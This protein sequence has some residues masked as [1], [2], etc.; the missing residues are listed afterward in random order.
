MNA[1]PLKCVSVGNQGCSMVI[2]N[3]NSN[4]SLFCFCS[5][6]VNKFSGSCNN[7]NNPYSKFLVPGVVKDMNFKVFNL[8]SWTNQT[9]QGLD[10]Y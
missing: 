1:I 2:L 8:M 4:E 10:S 9:C 7:I 6:T 3:V 5:I